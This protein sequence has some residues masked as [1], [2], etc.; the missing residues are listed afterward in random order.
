SF[1][2]T[3]FR[4][5]KGGDESRLAILAL[6][7]PRHLVTCPTAAAVGARYLALAEAT[8]GVAESICTRDWAGSLEILSAS[9]FGPRRLFPLAEMPEPVAELE[10]RVDGLPGEEGWAWDA[11]AQAVRFDEDATP[12]AG[13]IVEITY[14][15]GC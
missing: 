6:V 15:V 1:Y 4:G 5:L 13:S 11:A 7:G 8:G 2:E 10:V 12:A 9:A 3:F 14:P